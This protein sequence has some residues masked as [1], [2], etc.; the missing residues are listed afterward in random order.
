V[1]V[2]CSRAKAVRSLKEANGDLVNA[3]VSAP[4]SLCSHTSLTLCP[5]PPNVE[6]W[7]RASLRPAEPFL[8]H[9]C[10]READVTRFAQIVSEHEVRIKLCVSAGYDCCIV[11]HFIGMFGKK[12]KPHIFLPYKNQCCKLRKRR[13]KSKKRSQE[14]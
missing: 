13:G 3:C 4:V 5:P 6:S 11:K 7:Q 8:Y 1:K 9:S 14:C 12:I 10:Y 2:N